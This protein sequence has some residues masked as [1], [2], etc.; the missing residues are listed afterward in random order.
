MYKQIEEDIDVLEK[1]KEIVEYKDAKKK[2]TSVSLVFV[3][4]LCRYPIPSAKQM[5]DL[6]PHSFP[7]MSTKLS[8]PSPKLLR[9][10]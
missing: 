3:S 4:F 8:T 9:F 7:Q 6:L 2:A 1:K 5:I 10:F